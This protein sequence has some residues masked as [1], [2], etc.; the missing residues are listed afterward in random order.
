MIFG[1]LRRVKEGQNLFVNQKYLDLYF[2]Y[3][4]CVQYKSGPFDTCICV[5]L[6]INKKECAEVSKYLG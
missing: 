3:K 4:C 5:M 1:C 6:K 2:I